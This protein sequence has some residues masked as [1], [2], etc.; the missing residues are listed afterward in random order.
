LVK[1]KYTSKRRKIL[2][3]AQWKNESIRKRMIFGIKKS[4]TNG[5]I[6]KHTKYFNKNN[7][8]KNP[9]NR[10]KMRK[11]I[12]NQYKNGRIVWNKGLPREQQPFFNKK[13]LTNSK[14]LKNPKIQKIMMKARNTRP[15][16]QEQKIIDWIDEFRMPF[17]YVGAGDFYIGRKNPD[18]KHI[19]SNKVIEFN[20]FF[21]HTKE[22]EIKREKYF[23]NRGFNVLFL[24]KSDLKN[25]EECINKIKQFGGENDLTKNGDCS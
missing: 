14:R 22:E 17:N 11:T 16:K 19:F 6:K 9:E 20:G 10:E 2:V 21:T 8:M 24:H 13:N 23:K 25:K 18:F 12:I 5:R 7:P 3:K 15:N 1:I 4:W